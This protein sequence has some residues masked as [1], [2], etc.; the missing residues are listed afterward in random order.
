M[1]RCSHARMSE[2]ST[3]F[4]EGIMR[5]SF[6]CVNV[7]GSDSQVRMLYVSKSGRSMNWVKLIFHVYT[8]K[9]SKSVTRSNDERPAQVGWLHKN[10]SK[11]KDSGMRDT[12]LTTDSMEGAISIISFMSS[13]CG[14]N[15]T[16][17]KCWSSR[18]TITPESSHWMFSFVAWM[19]SKSISLLFKES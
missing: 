16:N 12:E 1:N 13:C 4:L 18:V 2:I 5:N 10:S 9:G 19:P 8:Y 7:R 3:G 15:S 14:Y 11:A 17:H 6:P